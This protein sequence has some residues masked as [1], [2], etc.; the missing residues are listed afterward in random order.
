MDPPGL[1]G[2]NVPPLEDFDQS[3]GAE[4]VSN[5]TIIRD[6]PDNIRNALGE[7]VN[8]EAEKEKARL[9]ESFHQYKRQWEEANEQKFRAMEVENQLLRQWVPKPSTEVSVN[10]TPK[11]LTDM[12]H[13]GQ[14]SL[15]KESSPS[16]DHSASSRESLSSENERKANKRAREETDI[17]RLDKNLSNLPKSGTRLPNKMTYDGLTFIGIRRISLAL[18]FARILGNIPAFTAREQEDFIQEELEKAKQG[19]DSD[20]QCNPD[21]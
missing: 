13:D 18:E 15:S 20:N 12:D 6:L 3:R 16:R 8:E 10:I 17:L 9:N 1:I 4:I 5:Q 2:D 19:E 11:P 7:M 21:K 14:K